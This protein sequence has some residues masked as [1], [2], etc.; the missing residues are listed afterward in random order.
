MTTTEKIIKISD[1]YNEGA[2]E[3]IKQNTNTVLS[4]IRDRLEEINVVTS[5]VE[6]ATCSAATRRSTI[7][8]CF[9]QDFL[10]EN[11]NQV[12]DNFYNNLFGVVEDVG[13]FFSD[14]QAKQTIHNKT[15]LNSQDLVE[16][17]EIV[18]NE[19]QNQI[20]NNEMYKYYDESKS[21]V[22]LHP[23]VKFMMM[24][25][26]NLKD[27][28]INREPKLEGG[29]C[30]LSFAKNIS[31]QCLIEVKK[32]G[33]QRTGVEQLKRYMDSCSIKHGLVLILAWADDTSDYEEKIDKA[34]AE[35]T[36]DGVTIKKFVLRCNQI[37]RP[38]PSRA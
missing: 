6:I 13:N 15:I 25:Y 26:C 35:N 24:S 2:R 9:S 29:L 8:K 28:I 27:I 33:H 17:I 23:I 12:V 30:D 20:S 4:D 22:D 21:E 10:G 5:Q 7:E 11:Y 3:G 32:H 16:Y 38:V 18:L 37:D 19:V 36:S 34:I 1:F 31:T 14:S